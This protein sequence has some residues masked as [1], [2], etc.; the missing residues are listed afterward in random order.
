[1]AVHRA[2]VLAGIKVSHNAQS[3]GDEILALDARLT[4]AMR[5]GTE[6]ATE[7]LYAQAIARINYRTGRTATT[8]GVDHQPTPKGGRGAVGSNDEIAEILERG[9]APHVI[10]PKPERVAR[11][12]AEGKRGPA[13]RF[14]IGA[15]TIYRAYVNHPG[16][17]AYRWLERSGTR[18][19]PLSKMAFD[20]AVGRVL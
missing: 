2:D 14:R 9:S 1:M 8:V 19:E 18:T 12:A 4:G 11:Y 6:A 5:E 7:L 13:L 3:M 10:R 16:T 15:R 20:R 17:R